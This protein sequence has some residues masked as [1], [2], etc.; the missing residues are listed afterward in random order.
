[1]SKEN[2]SASARVQAICGARHDSTEEAHSGASAPG[3]GAAS[4]VRSAHTR[5]SLASAD[6]YDASLAQL[7][8][9]LDAIRVIS[10]P[11][12]TEEPRKATVHELAALGRELLDECNQA[13][14][15]AFAATAREVA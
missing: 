7:R 9:V 8:A 10:A 14:R 12:A 3:V 6:R 15:V 4:G 5:Q 2:Q 1:M 11:N 13:G